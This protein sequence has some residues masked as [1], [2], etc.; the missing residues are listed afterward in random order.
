MTVAAADE[1]RGS[2]GVGIAAVTICAE[3]LPNGARSR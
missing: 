3:A 2:M 1:D